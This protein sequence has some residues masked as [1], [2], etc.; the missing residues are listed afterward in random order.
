MGV[1]NR[2]LVLQAIGRGLRIEAWR[3]IRKRLQKFFQTDQETIHQHITPEERRDLLRHNFPIETL[4][5]FATNKGIIQAII[6]DLAKKDTDKTGK[7]L[8]RKTTGLPKLP[9]PLYKEQ[10]IQNI[11]NFPSIDNSMRNS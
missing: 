7:E 2:K 4:F 3:Y 5:L 11:E 9:I 10:V 6:D 1:D 8:I